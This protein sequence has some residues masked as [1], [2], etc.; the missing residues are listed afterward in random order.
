VITADSSVLVAGFI[1][2]HPAHVSAR[3]AVT[4]VKEGGALIAHT[5]AEAYAVLSSPGGAFRVAPDLV[6]EY[7]DEVLA[8]AEPI[9]SLPGAHRE[10]L[11]LLSGDG[12]GG[13]SVYDALIAMTARDAGATLISLDRRAKTTYELCGVDARFLDAA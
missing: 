3:S 5:M 10:V 4:E 8:G 9:Q 11:E 7:L 1:G 12:R 6:V 2:E 13:A